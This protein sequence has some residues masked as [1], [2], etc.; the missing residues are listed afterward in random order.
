MDRGKSS[1]LLGKRD[2]SLL[3][4]RTNEAQLLAR[5]GLGDATKVGSDDGGDDRVAA[6]GLVIGEKYDRRAT[7]GHLD[8]ADDQSTRDELAGIRANA[9]TIQADAHP[10]ARRQDAEGQ[11]EE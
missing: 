11:I 8:R 5:H 6:G 9:R 2:D 3:A 7:A 10:I 4:R 1:P